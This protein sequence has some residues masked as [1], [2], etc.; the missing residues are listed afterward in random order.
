MMRK[1]DV[2]C[3]IG[4]LICIIGLLFNRTVA[5]IPDEIA[6]PLFIA[7]I[8]CIIYGGYRMNKAA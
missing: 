2:F 7:G 4:W 3:R 8:T 6:I 5:A 1:M